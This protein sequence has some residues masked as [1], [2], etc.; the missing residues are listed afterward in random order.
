MNKIKMLTQLNNNKPQKEF[1]N[2]LL[3]A[4]NGQFYQ[5]S[6]PFVGYLVG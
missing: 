6:Y 3:R 4:R 1:L 5:R 2:S